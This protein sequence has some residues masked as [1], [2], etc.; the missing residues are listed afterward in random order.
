M[1]V[2]AELAH[3]AVPID[4][5]ANVGIDVNANAVGPTDMNP[6]AVVE[7]TSAERRAFDNSAR[8]EA[9]DFGGGGKDDVVVESLLSLFVASFVLIDSDPEIF[10]A[11]LLF[12]SSLL[13]DVVEEEKNEM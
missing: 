6:N 11:E 4:A 9:V 7:T 3:S 1:N 10:L 13:F 2:A 12:S 5:A 8:L